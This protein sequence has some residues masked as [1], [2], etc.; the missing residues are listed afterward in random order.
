MNLLVLGATGATALLTLILG[1]L[2]RAGSVPRLG[3]EDSSSL[4]G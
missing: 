2:Q 3:S 4:I 1:A